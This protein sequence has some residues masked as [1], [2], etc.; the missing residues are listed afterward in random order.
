MNDYRRA[1]RRRVAET[2]EIRDV[3]AEQVV[4]RI[5]NLSESGMLALTRLELND[6]A[7]YQFRF[8]LT[9]RNGERREIEVGA[10]QLWADAAKDAGQFWCGLRFI[11]VDADDLR[12]IRD[13][14]EEPGS[15]HV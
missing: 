13:W 1:K 6:D 4:G 15:Q 7:L 3:M 12:F 2:I 11:D 14:V 5:G 10:H 8:L 9:N